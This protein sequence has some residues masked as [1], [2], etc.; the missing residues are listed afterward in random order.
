MTA[1]RSRKEV[2]RAAINDDK[3]RIAVM[4]DR[5]KELAEK[6]HGRMVEL[7]RYFHAHPETAFEEVQTSK[8]IKSELSRLKLKSTSMAKTGI[9]AVLKG[10]KEKPV[11]ALRSDIDAL[12]IDEKTDLP[13]KSKNEGRMHACGHDMHMAMV[14]GAAM[15][16]KDIKSDL[17]GTVRFIFQPAEEVPPG[18]AIEM[19]KAGAMKNPPV[20]MIFGLHNDPIIP[21]GRIGVRDGV[22][23]SE[24]L[25]FNL[26]IH[27]QGGHGARPHDA[28]DSI[29]IASQI[30][31]AAQS[32]VARRINPNS[33][34][35]L[36]FGT[37]EGGR[38]RNIIAGEV[39][40]EG[41]IRGSDSKSVKTVKKSLE[42]IVTGITNANGAKYNLEYVAN[43]PALKNNPLANRFIIE[44][45]QELYGKNSVTYLA[46]PELGGEDFARYLK[47]APGAMF[48]LGVR[49]RD[50]GAVHQWHS[51]MFNVDEEAMKVGSAV[52]AGAVYNFLDKKG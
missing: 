24:V 6:Y 12:P 7:R 32:I 19:I 17:N 2:I 26:T 22:M 18:G 42:K 28:V 41:T 25:D 35:V 3:K 52:L 10:K 43:Y 5:I 31:N 50:V 8:K 51:N 21:S 48:R 13:F 20:K 9:M 47:Y 49:N 1:G 4:L 45:A 38:A 46:N 16:L 30:I 27:G 39:S 14:L 29:V 15:I 44:T 37:I 33:R 23:M 11:C 34:A 36:T 40:L